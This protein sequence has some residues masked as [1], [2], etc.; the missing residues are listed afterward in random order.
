M[1][2]IML[3][4]MLVGFSV[5]GFGADENGIYIIFSKVSCGDWVKERNVEKLGNILKLANASKQYA[6]YESAIM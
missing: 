5:S 1:K 4:A 3:F 2:N 6:D